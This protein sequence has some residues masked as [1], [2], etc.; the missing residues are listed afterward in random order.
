MLDIDKLNLYGISYSTRLMLGF[1]RDYPNSVRS[2][3]IESTMPIES[4]YDEAGVDNIFRSLDLFFSRCKADANC[5][6]NYPKL[7]SDVFAL[8]KQWNKKPLAIKTKDQAG[9]E[10][11]IK[12][13]GD[14][15]ITWLVD[16][17]LSSYG[18]AIIAAPGQISEILGGKYDALAD[19][20]QFK[21][22]P[23]STPGVCVTP[24]GAARKCR[25]RIGKGSGLKAQNH[26]RRN[27]NPN[28]CPTSAPFGK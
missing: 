1:V 16:Y 27:T 26:N 5:S 20:A 13:D 21:L 22:F 7:E 10:A 17:V 4:N 24:F 15:L 9:N 2:L 28:R 6:G 14:D 19:Y 25:S 11:V 18:R 8:A 3:V 23:R 12:L